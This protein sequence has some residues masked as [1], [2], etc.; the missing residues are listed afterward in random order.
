MVPTR[1]NHRRSSSSSV[2]HSALVLALAECILVISQPVQVATALAMPSSTKTYNYFAFGSNMASATMRELRQL[3][4]LAST[5]A[6]LPRHELRFNLPGMPLVEPSWASV[7]PVETE[8]DDVW[9]EDTAETSGVSVVHGVLYKL[10]EE[11]FLSVCSTEGVPFGY[12]L[13]RCRPIP[14]KGNGKDAGRL[15]LSDPKR[16]RGVAAYT[17]RAARK[18]YRAQPKE[19]DPRPS[20]SYMNVLIRG[21]KE[22]DLDV[23]Y[24][25]MLEKLP[26]GRTLLGNGTAERMLEVAVA[27]NRRKQ[28]MKR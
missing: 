22:F 10:T 26:V 18:E 8:K 17:L 19:Q 4:P 16:N 21:A 27:T 13:H 15:A 20:Q 12:T 28:G 14:Y 2:I 3:S 24:V 6:V 23:D 1:D 7:E 5:A 25:D 9:G 11:D